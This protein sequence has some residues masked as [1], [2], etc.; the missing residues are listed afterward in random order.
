MKNHFLPLF[1]FCCTA[2]QSSLCWD[3]VHN[4]EEA[5]HTLALWRCSRRLCVIAKWKSF[6][7]WKI[8]VRVSTFLYTS[9]IILDA[10]FWTCFAQFA[11]TVRMYCFIF[12]VTVP[13][14]EVNG[15]W[16]KPILSVLIINLTVTRQPLLDSDL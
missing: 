6:A 16:P 1:W 13:S 10:V 15:D 7:R 14:W 8:K 5:I 11:V 4:L 12:S 2:A 3:R 9:C